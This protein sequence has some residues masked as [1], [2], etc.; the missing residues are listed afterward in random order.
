LLGFCNQ[1]L[2]REPHEDQDQRPGKN[3]AHVEQRVCRKSGFKRAL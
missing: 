3:T 1:P 2:Q